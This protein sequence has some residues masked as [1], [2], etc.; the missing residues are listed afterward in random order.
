MSRKVKKTKDNSRIVK[1]AEKVRTTGESNL[2]VSTDLSFSEN[3]H[4]TFCFYLY[5]VID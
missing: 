2:E 3:Q 4:F 1:K 5:F